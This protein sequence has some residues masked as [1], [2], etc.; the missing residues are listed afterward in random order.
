MSFFSE[1]IKNMKTIGSITPSSKHLCKGAIKHVEFDQAEFLVEL[2]A[3]DGVITKFILA[4]MRPESKLMVFEV[5][6][7]FCN[8]LR[9]IKDSRLIV[10]ED[11]AQKIDIYLKLNNFPRVDDIISAIPFVV[12]PEK[13]AFSIVE[14]CKSV[15]KTGGKFIQVHYSL[16]AKK[17][18]KKVFGNV[19]VNFVP[20]NLP[21]AFILVSVK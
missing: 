9:A 14:A 17:M 11:S 5:N 16:V 1:G 15:L 6:K 8:Q 10:V 12:V 21:P 18:Y 4:S 7:V 20:L 19:D 13:E 3:G 2:G